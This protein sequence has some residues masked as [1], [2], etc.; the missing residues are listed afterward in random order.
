MALNEEF[1][2]AIKKIFD[3]W[4]VEVVPG[5]ISL[6]KVDLRKEDQDAKA[7]KTRQAS[8]AQG[9][10]KKWL[11]T[12]IA[13][14]GEIR[15][16]DYEEAVAELKKPENS[17]YR[18]G[19]VAE[20]GNRAMQEMQGAKRIILEGGGSE[21]ERAI[22]TG[23]TLF[24]GGGSGTLPASSGGTSPSGGGGSTGGPKTFSGPERGE[25]ESV[26]AWE[27]RRRLELGV[28]PKKKSKGD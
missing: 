11:G 4:G 3:D 25:G 14:W 16:L 18:D 6:T 12:L 28:P 24:G 8:V 5:S 27:A 13:M 22:A 23:A 26:E 2:L 17:A 15:G 20:A 10:A 9:T 21:I 7:A 1:L 19:L